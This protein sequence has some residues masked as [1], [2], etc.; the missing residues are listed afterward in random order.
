MAVALGGLL[1]ESST[2]RVEQGRLHA[3]GF[4][5]IAAGKAIA[6][7]VETTVREGRQG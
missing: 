5:W 3:A 4:T 6:A 2:D 7:S 1:G